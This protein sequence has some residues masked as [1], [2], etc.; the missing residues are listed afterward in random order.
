MKKVYIAMIEP[1]EIGK[2]IFRNNARMVYFTSR[3]EAQKFINRLDV[4]EEG[5]I[6]I[7]NVPEEI[8][9]KIDFCA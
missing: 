2:A 7:E 8:Y 4:Y 9:V 3:K 6:D 5:Y 1:S